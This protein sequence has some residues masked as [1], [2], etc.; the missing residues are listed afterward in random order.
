MNMN[1]PEG[2]GNIPESSGEICAIKKTTS[3]TG[4]MMWLNIK[5]AL[6]RA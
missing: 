4:V 6:T 3:F 5:T 1:I 2:S